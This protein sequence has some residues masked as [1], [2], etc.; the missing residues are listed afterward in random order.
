MI[1][2]KDT[3]Y[4]EVMDVTEP[5]RSEQDALDLVALCREHYANRLMLHGEVFGDE[6]FD[7]KTGLAGAVLQKFINY[8]IKAALVVPP[9][10]ANRGRF[11]E[12]VLE[13][14]RGSHFRVF[15]DREDAQNWLITER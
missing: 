1:D 7:L 3:K 9:E 15:S 8:Y 14:N 6:F 13:A 12:M 2:G 11:R 10:K 5:V 4:I